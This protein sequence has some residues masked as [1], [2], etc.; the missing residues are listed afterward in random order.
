MSKTFFTSPHPFITQ[1]RKAH[2]PV[3]LV[4]QNGFSAWQKKQSAVIRSQISQEGFSAASPKALVVKSPAGNV[5]DVYAIVNVPLQF[6]DLAKVADSIAKTFS[7]DFLKTASFELKGIKAASLTTAHI[8][9]GMA[10]YDFGT[11][12]SR[13]S[14]AVFPALL[15]STGTDKKRVKT[16]IES[17]CL[18]RNLVNTPANDLGPHELEKAASSLAEKYKAVIKTISGAALKKGFPLVHAVGDSSPRRPRLIDITWGAAS[19]PKVTLVGK[20]V[21]FDTGGLDLKPSAAMKLMKKDMG[22]AAHALAIAN[23]IM[24]LKLPVRLRVIIPAVENSVSGTSFRPGDI[25]KSR[26]GITVE[27]T[28][29]DAEGRL[30]LADTLTLASEDK[31]EIIIDFA[32]LTGS[33]RA[34]LGPDI[35]AMFSNN[36]K[37]AARLQKT[38][39]DIED[40]LWYMPL[41][42]P[43][44]KHIESNIA[45]LHNSAGIPGDL[46]YSALFLESFLNGKPDWVHIDT[47]AW[48]QTGHAGRPRGGADCGMRAVFTFLEERYQK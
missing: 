43:Y 44:R 25:F 8:G 27:N 45:E 23:M 12:K 11:Y 17:I 13:K 14:P 15:W 34:A 42:Q 48:E 16:V 3:H 35:P 39:H 30:I 10:A 19:H 26:K 21:C 37:I 46:I 22:G 31:P 20:G 28:N 4:P 18:L 33:A 32:T 40:P 36:E 24:A 41:W 38:A 1:K 29:T 47:Y 2:I 5:R 9:W 7:K 6:Y